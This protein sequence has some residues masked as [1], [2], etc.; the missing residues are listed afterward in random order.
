MSLEIFDFIVD[1]SEYKKCEKCGF[2]EFYCSI[3]FECE[4]H[5]SPRNFF[6]I[7]DVGE[8]VLLKKNCKNCGHSHKEVIVL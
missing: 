3:E 2:K 7:D 8:S 6:Y 1:L 5:H 4:I